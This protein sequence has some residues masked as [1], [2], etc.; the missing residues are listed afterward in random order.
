MAAYYKVEVSLGV[1][2]V[3]V[4]IPSAQK[5]DVVLPLVGPQGPQGTP[6]PQGPQGTP[7]PQGASAVLADGVT[8]VT[9]RTASGAEFALSVDDDGVLTTTRL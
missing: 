6:G 5:V 1:N 3:E 4:G 7:G 9:L 2:A 8:S